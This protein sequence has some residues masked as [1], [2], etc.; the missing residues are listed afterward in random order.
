MVYF[1]LEYVLVDLI[2]CDEPDDEILQFEDEVPPLDED[3]WFDEDDDPL[4]QFE[5]EEP[6]LEE[7]D[8]DEELFDEV[9]CEDPPLELFVW[10]LDCDCEIDCC[11]LPWIMP[12]TAN[13]TITHRMNFILIL[14]NLANIFQSF[15]AKNVRK[16]LFNY[17]FTY[18]NNKI[19]YVVFLSQ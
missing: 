14:I 2:V 15:I 6:P 1:P 3:T 11:G 16:Y 8:E 19:K 5:E 18:Y 10:E 13:K 12:A 4:L 17:K 9:F 7:F